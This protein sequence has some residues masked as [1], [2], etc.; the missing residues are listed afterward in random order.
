MWGGSQ[1]YLLFPENEQFQ[2]K[3]S[4]EPQVSRPYDVCFQMEPKS[5]LFCTFIPKELH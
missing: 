2:V 4:I 5:F 1:W 3:A